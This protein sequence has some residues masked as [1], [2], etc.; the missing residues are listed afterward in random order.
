MTE[1]IERTETASVDLYWLP[2]GAGEAP[3]LVRWS[4]RLFESVVAG[5]ERRERRDL[6]HSALEV[7][8]D[9]DRFV[10]EMTPVWGNGQLGR[11]VVCQGAVGLPQLGRSQFFRYEVRRWRSGTIPDVAEGVNSP[12]RLSEASAPARRL[13]SLVPDFPTVTWGR[14]E[15]HTGDMWNSNSLVS[16][17]LERSGHDTDLVHPPPRGRAPGWAA[18]LVV[19]RRQ[20]E[21]PPHCH[22][23]REHPG[24][25]LWP[26]C[27]LLAR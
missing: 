23:V 2:V 24:T 17:L 20:V 7:S 14:D 1:Y 16:W 15:L 8:L 13:L 26:S 6:Y 10:I 25:R 12:I 11:G 5:F 4:G 22:L 27:Q 3:G 9:G 19:A 18:G 21:R